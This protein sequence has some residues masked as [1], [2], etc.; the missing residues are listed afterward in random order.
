LIKT[1]KPKPQ[2]LNSAT[3]WH[4]IDSPLPMLSA[5]VGLALTLTAS[6]DSE[7][8]GEVAAHLVWIRKQLRL[9]R[10]HRHVHIRDG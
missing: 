9:L 3:A 2:N 6:I 5:L 7:R 8:R 4:D 10:N 1:A